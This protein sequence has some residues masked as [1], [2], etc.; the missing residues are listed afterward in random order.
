MTQLATRTSN[1]AA[2]SAS[3]LRIVGT[4]GTLISLTVGLVIWQLL[5][6]RY[7]P[8]TLPGP[9]STA[10]AAWDLIEDGTLLDSTIASMK[11]IAIGWALGVI[12]GVPVGLV[13]GEIPWVR[14]LLDPYLQFF[15]FVPPI[16]LVTLAII[17]FGIGES[18]KIFLIFYTTVFVIVL[19]TV[20]GT[21]SVDQSRIQAARTFGANRF[22]VLTT[23]ILPSV[24]PH[25][26]VGARLAMGNSFLTIV[27]A[28]IVAA[29]V[30]LGSLIWT[31]RNYGQTEWVFV[32]IITL[33]L[34]G[35]IIDS[36]I[37][38]ISRTLL[39]RFEVPA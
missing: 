25:I 22:Q 11:R 8:S 1:D 20:A 21:L 16:S 4:S 28:E 10:R 19:N 37:R 14:R 30:G 23:I 32:G 7:D 3:R 9:Q 27:S 36:A 39:S 12:V 17:W 5:S 38:W 24:I 29:Q 31:A 35:L 13:V 6:M 15:R 34:L 33:G 18:S 2:R 26:V